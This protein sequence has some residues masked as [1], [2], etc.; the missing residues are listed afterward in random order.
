MVVFKSTPLRGALRF[1]CRMVR[2]IGGPADSGIDSGLPL[3]PGRR[4]GVPTWG[5]SPN[6]TPDGVRAAVGLFVVV[7]NV[8]EQPDAVNP[9]LLWEVMR[10]LARRSRWWGLTWRESY[11]ITRNVPD[12]FFVLYRR[13][14]CRGAEDS[15][16]TVQSKSSFD[17]SL[18]PSV[19]L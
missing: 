15:E 16:W 12:D 3:P 17:R 2:L 4:I 8:I 18:E 9:P 10:P 11:S 1:M 14:V 7:Q 6:P 19:K 5:P 13:F